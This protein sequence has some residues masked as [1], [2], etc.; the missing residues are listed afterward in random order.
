MVSDYVKTHILPLFRHE[1]YFNTQPV[2]A[3]LEA[4]DATRARFPV[5]SN[6]DYVMYMPKHMLR[7]KAAHKRF[8]EAFKGSVGDIGDRNGS[9]NQFVEG[10]VATV[11]KN[12]ESLDTFDWDASLLPY[13]DG[14]FDSVFCLDTLEHITDIHTRFADLLR[15]TKKYAVV[16]LPNCW[17]KT[18][19][20]MIGGRSIRA[21][22][23]LPVEKPMDRHRWY[24]NTEE[25]EDFLF[26][27]AAKNGFDVEGVLYHLPRIARWHYVLSALRPIIPERYFKN[28]FIANVFVLLRRKGS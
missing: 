23:G 12:N 19:R 7:Y 1:H 11:D 21:S 14:Q 26:Y 15:V 18:P 13:A 8:P 10:N 6:I 17:R 24:M 20:E 28:F 22:Y 4:I 2:E 9:I 27:N 5:G 25:I 16:S 3:Y